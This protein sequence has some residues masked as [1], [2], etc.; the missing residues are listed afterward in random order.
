MQSGM[1]AAVP[2]I[3]MLVYV[4]MMVVM[5]GGWIVFLVAA[6]RGMKAHEAVAESLRRIAEKP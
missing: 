3:F 4:V 1:G 5:I 2:F 6:W